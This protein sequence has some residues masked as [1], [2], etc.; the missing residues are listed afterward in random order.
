MSDLKDLR[1]LFLEDN[2]SFANH[3]ICFLEMYLKEVL[4]CTNI[5]DAIDIFKKEHIDII[6]SDL[7]VEDGLSLNFIEQIRALNKDI[8]IAVLSAHK[9]EEFLLKAIPLGLVA[10]EL[11]PINF[12]NFKLL[13]N[14]CAE[15]IYSNSLVDIKDGIRYDN[16]RKS[17]YINT[18]EV[19]LNKK[20]YLFV[21]LLI[22]NKNSITTKD[23]INSYIWDNEIMSES[24][25]KNFLLR[26]RKKLGKDFF[27]T[28]Q[29]IGYR[30]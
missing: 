6:I 7:K 5:K 1:V 23:E 18:E 20:E 27:Y 30:L 19:I 22:K 10:Y 17:I 25:L 15:T 29:N 28:I 12:S 13:L 4:H 24:A 3:T 16:N 2:L 11:K 8:P 21:E 26:V 9:D 14:K